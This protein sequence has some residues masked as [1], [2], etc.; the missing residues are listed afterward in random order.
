MVRHLLRSLYVFGLLV[1]AARITTAQ[2]VTGT[3]PFDSFGGGPDVINLA[4]VNVHLDVPVLNKPGRG[5]NLTYDLTYDSSVWYP[6]GSSGSQSW[7]PVSAFGWQ[8]LT[9]GNSGYITYQTTYNSSTCYN[10]GPTPYSWWTCSN[11]IYFDQYG[12]SHP[13]YANIAYYQSP[14]GPNCPPNGSNPPSPLVVTVP[15]GSGLTMTI[16]A[17]SGTASAFVSTTMGSNFYVPDNPTSPNA[18]ITITDRN[19]NQI[20]AVNG[21]Y[22]DTLGQSALTLGGAGNPS[23]PI[24]FTYSAP[25]GASALYTVSFRTYTVKTN[26]GCSGISEYGPTSASLVD[27]IT[28][29]DGSFYQFNYEA[30][31][32]F[33]GDFTARLASVTLPT[34]GTITYAYT[35]GSNGITCADGSTAGLTRT[36]PDGT[37]SYARAGS[38]AAYTTTITD[39]QSNQTVIQFQGLYETQRQVYQGSTSGT[40]LRTWNTCY[41]GS[42]S[43]CTSTA[44]SLPITRRTIDQY[45][46]GAL[47]CKHDYIYDSTGL[48]LLTE[49][50]DYDYGNGAP[51]AALRKQLIAYASLGNGIVSA[52]QT[53]TTQDG[54]GAVKAQTTITYDQGTTVATSGTPQHIAISGS[55]GNPTTIA[56]LVQSS[57]TLN[58]S[59]TYFDT[60]NVQTATDVNSAQTTN[61]YGSGSCG[62]S[63]PTTLNEPLSMSRSYTWNCNVGLLTQL[64]DENSQSTTFSY[65]S[66]FRPTQVNFPDGGQTSW[67]YNVTSLPVTVTSTQKMNSSQNIVSTVL[68]D[69]LGRTT[70]TQL[71]SDPD[72]SV[73]DKTDTAYD[74]LGRIHTVSNPY[75]TTGDST[76]GLND[77]CL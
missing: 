49:Q 9:N 39:P 26:F 28:L 16:T 5:T 37:W 73:G 22:T 11:F 36:T 69:G 17:S 50:D 77:V 43:P 54:G 51:G 46:S 27:R 32:G 25:S 71:N 76:Y 20:T 72:C 14:G 4:N 68:L 59:F 7:Q 10:G 56:S 62:N 30:T 3:P 23:S 21:V 6:V 67:G 64:T 53:I 29:P 48:G 52:P 18:P 63:F 66:M 2:V 70:Q 15:D 75:C 57:T 55:R 33:S 58:R 60:G 19:G 24:T 38:G 45:G 13:F 41:N 40:L 42:A 31:P 61:V 1:F 65:D 44:V 34:G 47:Q 12:T 74:A 8:G 35:G